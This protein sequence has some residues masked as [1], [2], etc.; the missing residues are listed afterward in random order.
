MHN[1]HILI[2]IILHK[3]SSK[4]FLSSFYSA[5]VTVSEIPNKFFNVSKLNYDPRSIHSQITYAWV[6]HTR[7]GE[8]LKYQQ[9]STFL[10]PSTSF[11][12]DNFSMDQSGGWDGLG[13]SQA[14]YTY[15]ALLFQLLLLHQLH[16]GASGIWSWRWRT[17]LVPM[18][19]W[20]ML[21]LASLHVSEVLLPPVQINWSAFSLGHSTFSFSI[22]A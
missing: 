14:H 20:F 2:S 16:L 7:F 10:V 18:G 1:T 12:K 8:Y 11:V 15:W 3:N 9:P 4:K 6:N 17:L 13:M 21:V 19:S 22:F 5:E